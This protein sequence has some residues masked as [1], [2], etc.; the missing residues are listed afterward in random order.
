M[1]VITVTLSNLLA[2]PALVLTVLQGIYFATFH[3]TKI[4]RLL[5]LLFF[6]LGGFLLLSLGDSFGFH[7]LL[8]FLFGRMAIL[9]PGVLWLLTFNLFADEDKV[10]PGFWL[11]LALY[12]LLHSFGSA[13]SL[14]S[15]EPLED[16]LPLYLTLEL[17]PLLVMVGLTLHT[18]YLAIRGY[19]SDLIETRRA[20][21]VAFVVCLAILVLTVLGNGIYLAAG[22]L[23]FPD[24]PPARALFPDSLIAVYILALMIGFH[25]FTF[26]LRD[27]VDS[28]VRLPEPQRDANGGEPAEP[29]R[30]G[31]EKALAG[32]IIAVME[33]E[34]LY[35]EEKYT[36]TQFAEHLGIPEH[37]LRPIINRQLNYRNF[38]Q[39]LNRFRV[40]EAASR[41]SGSNTP[42]STIAYQVGFATLS[43]FNR[44]FKD[45]LG[46]TPT[47]YRQA[48]PETPSVPDAPG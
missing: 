21:R 10:R 32:R 19:Y 28:L 11:L 37:R 33:E 23:L 36:I 39:F 48:R 12:F 29:A 24:S 14:W 18:F 8:G 35:R 15:G 7:P 42:V 38:N 3:G 43:A 4:S 5:S 47:E 9:I 25:F 46:R 17:I 13:Y 31:A 27:S 2:L 30:N 44:S 26:T 40:R 16:S 6:L 45:Q 41:L 1:S 20:A 34:K 22:S